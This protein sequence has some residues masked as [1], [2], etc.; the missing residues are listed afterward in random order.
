[1]SLRAVDTVL[2]MRTKTVNF[3]TTLREAKQ[4]VVAEL[5]GIDAE[6]VGVVSAIALDETSPQEEV[7]S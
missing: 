6:T 1:M 7:E 3:A 2:S 4:L 5:R